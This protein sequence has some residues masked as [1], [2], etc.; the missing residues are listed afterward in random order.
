LK[1]YDYAQPGHYF[2]TVCTQGHQTLF[3]DVINGQM[4]RAEGGEMVH[5]VWYELPHRFPGAR[6]D[7][8]IVMPNHIHGVLELFPNRGIPNSLGT[9]VGAFKSITT[10]EYLARVKTRGWRVFRRRLWQRNYYEHIVRT[11]EALE[12]IREYICTNPAR[13]AED[14]LNPMRLTR[15][16]DDLDDIIGW[17]LEDSS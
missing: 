13:W 11:D 1:G 16:V 6:T 4:R 12:R 5:R 3:G 8:F 2:V 14:P 10:D 7:A 15:D 9:I 17:D